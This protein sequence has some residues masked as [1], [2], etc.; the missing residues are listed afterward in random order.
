MLLLPLQLTSP[1]YLPQKVY[2]AKIS[3]DI[4]FVAQFPVSQLPIRDQYVEYIS[5]YKRDR[6]EASKW[7]NYLF[8]SGGT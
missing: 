4:D 2:C 8:P 1:Y 6:Y 5:F 7:D 3:N